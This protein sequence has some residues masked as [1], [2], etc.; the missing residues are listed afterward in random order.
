LTD[1]ERPVDFVMKCIGPILFVLIGFGF[2]W[3]GCFVQTELKSKILS[4]KLER[5]W[6]KEVM[7]IAEVHSMVQNELLRIRLEYGPLNKS[8][9]RFL[10]EYLSNAL[11]QN[12]DLSFID[13]ASYDRMGWLVM[14]CDSSFK[15]GEGILLAAPVGGD[16]FPDGYAERLLV[17]PDGQVTW[18][19]EVDFLKTLE[20]YDWAFI[21]TLAK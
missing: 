18:E 12:R 3:M 9:L 4:R 11:I 2:G 13:P 1:Q 6:S 14:Y 10:K 8:E 15:Y 7:K 16:A 17:R 20:C 21:D 5:E 19:K